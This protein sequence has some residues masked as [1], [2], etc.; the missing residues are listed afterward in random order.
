[1]TR[2]ADLTVS[3]FLDALS[4]AAPT[5][6]GGTASAVAGAMAASLLMMVA[7]LPK[8]RANT[9]DEKAALAEA[10]PAIAGVRTELVALADDDSA[11]FDGVMAAFRKPK[12]TGDQNQA[13]SAAIQAATRLATEAPLRTLR[14]CADLSRLA[15][16]VARHGNRSASSDVGVALGLIDAASAGA[17]ANVRINLEALKDEAFRAAAGAETRDRLAQ[18]AAHR[19]AADA[20]LAS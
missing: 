3:G 5:P 11:A 2:F 15:V 1:V 13:R 19:A 12:A 14:A 16:T 10:A 18:I 20:S 9:D 6:G 7:G 17:A 4:S 8:S